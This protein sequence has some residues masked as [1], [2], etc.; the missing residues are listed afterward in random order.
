MV[1]RGAKVLSQVM[2]KFEANKIQVSAD[3]G[4]YLMLECADSGQYE[5]IDRQVNLSVATQSALTKFK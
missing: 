2:L 5:L 1:L 3:A 4:R